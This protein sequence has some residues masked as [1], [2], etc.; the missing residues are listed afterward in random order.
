MLL[1]YEC[2]FLYVFLSGVSPEGPS[3]ECTFRCSA[4]PAKKISTETS[5]DVLEYA[6][7][8]NYHLAV[9][10]AYDGCCDTKGLKKVGYRLFHWLLTR[11]K[12]YKR[13]FLKY[14]AMA[15]QTDQLCR[16]LYS[17]ETSKDVDFD[18]CSAKM[19]SVLQ[20]II[21]G[22]IE[23]HP[24]ENS[25]AILTFAN[26][27][28]M[29]IYLID[30]Y[31]DFEKDQKKK[32]FNPLSLFSDMDTGDETDQMCLRAGEVMLGMMTTNLK[33]LLN[34]IHIY[35]HNEVLEN[36]VW[37]G[38]QNSVNICKKKKVKKNDCSCKK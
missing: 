20:E 9:L 8:V 36:I 18:S 3:Q 13:M 37:F 33:D 32:A 4:N 7:F 1:N 12:R 14:Q 17:L 6:S 23:N 29:W 30:A 15:T 35:R 10:K 2:T 25:E 27:L 21:N 38:T 5:G 24:I 19:G 26:H 28:G 34:S 31:D 16:D 11:N 22:F